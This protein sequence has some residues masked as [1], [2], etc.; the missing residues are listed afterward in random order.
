LKNRVLWRSRTDIFHAFLDQ[1]EKARNIN[2]CQPLPAAPRDTLATYDGQEVPADYADF[3]LLPSC[4]GVLWC[5]SLAGP[6]VPNRTTPGG[7]DY[8]R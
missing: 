6:R 7:R 2:D 3:D 8:R 1:Q 5:A 4:A